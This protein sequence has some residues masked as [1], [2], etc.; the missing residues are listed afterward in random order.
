MDPVTAT[1]GAAA[2]SGLANI[3]GGFMSA[4]GASAAN[5]ANAQL[6]LQNQNFQNNVNAADWEH[7]QAVNQEN[8]IH[9][10]NVQ[11]QNQDFARQQTQVGQDFAREQTN[12]SQA[13]AQKQMDFQA[14]MSNTAY[15]RAMADMRA[16]GLNPI[17]AYSQ[18]G[19]S[20]PSGAAGSAQN[21]PALGASSQS[22]VSQNASLTAPQNKFAMGNTQEELGRA[23]GRAASSAVDTYRMGEDARL[24][25][26]QTG[27]TDEQKNTQKSTQSN[28]SQDTN[29]KASQGRAAE[30]HGDLSVEQLNTERSR[31]KAY[32]ASSAASYAA[33]READTRSE[34]NTMRNN[35]AKPID[36][37]GRGRGTGVGP[38]LPERFGR[39]VEDLGQTVTRQLIP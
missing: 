2:I 19:A 32:S 6:N 9:S 14:N 16:A 31:Q 3:G 20:T 8:W 24:K 17:L 5:A 29:L 25:T 23:V 26:S 11:T 36:Q 4:Q 30:K 1:L 21:A 37:G 10:Q 15:Q 39:Q 12:A 13:F 35:E 38:S 27:L 34:F 22:S 33:A 7:Q 28:L 18:G